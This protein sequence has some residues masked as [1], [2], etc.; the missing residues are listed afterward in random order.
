MTLHQVRGSEE[1]VQRC[2]ILPAVATYPLA[3]RHP[4]RP[5]DRDRMVSFTPGLGTSHPSRPVHLS[6]VSIIV[7]NSTVYH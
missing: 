6:G 7:S 1:S 4:S 3:L 2:S 5:T